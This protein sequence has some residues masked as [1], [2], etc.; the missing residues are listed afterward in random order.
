VR[1]YALERL[2]E[3]PDRDA[4]NERLATWCLRFLPEATAH[5]V[6]ADRAPWLAKLN[7]ELPNALAALSWALD[8]RR[9][10]PALQLVDE[11]GDYWWH[12]QQSEDALRWIDAALELGRDVAPRLRAAA[13]LNRGRLTDVRRSDK[14]NRGDLQASLE[15]YRACDDARGI[16]ACLTHL[17]FTEIWV[18][19]YDRASAL[20]EKAVRYA[21]RVQ[22]QEAIASALA[23]GVDSGGGRGRC[24][25]RP[26]RGA[27]PAPRRQPR[28]AGTCLLDRRVRSDHRAP[29]PRR[30]RLARRSPRRRAAAR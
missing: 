16:A 10:E 8:A 14:P 6:R 22:D 17:A 18:G 5:L 26:Q 20:S 2:A 15:I 24:P 11:L 13:L 7:A 28:R 21:E 19:N 3:D 9:P 27:V 4:V 1:E 30:A 12:T 23:R 25:P 29:P